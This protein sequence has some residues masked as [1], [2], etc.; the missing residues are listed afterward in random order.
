MPDCDAATHNAGGANP[1]STVAGKAQG[2]LRVGAVPSGLRLQD[3]RP[4]ALWPACGVRGTGPG[5]KTGPLRRGQAVGAGA[6]DPAGNA[7]ACRMDGQAGAPVLVRL[8]HEAPASPTASSTADNAL[9]V[10]LASLFEG[11]TFT[12]I[13]E[14]TY[15]QPLQPTLA[16]NC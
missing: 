1:A 7:S 11:R 9:P 13:V 12:D 5:N 2:L 4:L 10:D 15:V 16:R 14:T 8:L 6:V 3:T